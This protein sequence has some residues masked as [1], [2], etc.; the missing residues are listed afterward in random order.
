MMSRF[1]PPSS[2][3]KPGPKAGVRV[4]S[5]RTIGRVRSWVPAFAGMTV[6][7]AGCATMGEGRR[8]C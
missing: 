2:Q 3:R 4:A 1:V 5:A 8:A 6:E 7:G